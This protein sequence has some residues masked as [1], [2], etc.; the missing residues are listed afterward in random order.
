MAG[1]RYVTETGV[2][3]DE[4][5]VRR[6]RTDRWYVYSKCRGST[7]DAMQAGSSGWRRL[8]TAQPR[9]RLPCLEV[10]RACDAKVART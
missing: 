10:C 3:G 2:G 9:R 8:H 6:G 5:T 4:G 7:V 1:R